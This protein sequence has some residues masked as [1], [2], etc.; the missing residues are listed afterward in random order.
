MLLLLLL[1]QRRILIDN[2]NISFQTSL[3]ILIIYMLLPIT[4]PGMTVIADYLFETFTDNLL[5]F[6]LF[7]IPLLGLSFYYLYRN[8]S[9]REDTFL[10]RKVWFIMMNILLLIGFIC[11]IFT[12]HYE[13]GVTPL[14]TSSRYLIGYFIGVHITVIIVFLM[15]ILLLYKCN[16]RSSFTWVKGVFTSIAIIIYLAILLDISTKNTF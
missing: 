4:Y 7:F 5:W 10:T 13:N 11:A 14:V 3:N 6:S 2:E 8:L 9:L 1:M 15:Q 16:W 12:S